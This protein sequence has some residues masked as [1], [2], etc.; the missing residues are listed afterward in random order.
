[1]EQ[2]CNIDLPEPYGDP[3]GVALPYVVTVDLTSK[4]VLSIK[5]N[6]KPEDPTRERILHFTHYKYVPGFAF[7]GLGLIHFLGNLTMTATTAMRS[8]VDAGQFANLP[9]G[10]K[11]RGVRLVGDNE[12]ISPGEFKEVESTGIDL[13]K[14]IV[15]LPYKEPSNTLLQMLQFV[16]QAGQKFAD[17]T[18]NIIK[19]S[20]NYGPV[21][22]TMALLDASSKFS[23]AIHHRS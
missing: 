3:S 12:P 23:T 18:E 5:R 8:L 9:G 19:D 1:M 4:Q 17:S 20:S 7:Y 14:A 6:Y 22:T 15:P 2:H 21:G 11:A 10:F 13:T 16:V